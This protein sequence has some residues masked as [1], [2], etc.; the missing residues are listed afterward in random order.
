M[1]YLHFFANLCGEMESEFMNLL[2]DCE[3]SWLSKVKAL[4]RVIMLKN[5]VVIFLT[6]KNSD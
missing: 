5:K 3:V 6:E 1:L 4:K 2:L